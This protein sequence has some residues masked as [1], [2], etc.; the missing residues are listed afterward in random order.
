MSCLPEGHR[1]ALA[2][3]L[4]RSEAPQKDARREIDVPDS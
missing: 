3:L 1:P 4:Q 2:A